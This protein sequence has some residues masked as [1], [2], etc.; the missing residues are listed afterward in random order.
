MCIHCSCICLFIYL[1]LVSTIREEARRTNL[2]RLMEIHGSHLLGASSYKD[3][4]TSFPL[5]HKFSV[6]HPEA[7]AS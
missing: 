2:G 5:F 4:I 6:Q 1:L 7:S 3:P